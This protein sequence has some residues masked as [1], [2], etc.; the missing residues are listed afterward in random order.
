LKRSEVPTSSIAVLDE[1]IEI[2]NQSP[3]DVDLFDWSIA[4]AV[5]VRHR[6]YNGGV[7]ET[8]SASNA[9]IVFGG[10]LNG[11]TPSLPVLAFPA[12]EGSAGLALNNTG[13]ESIILRN[14]TNI[15]DRLLYA[16][17]S[18]SPVGSLTRFPTLN[19]PFVPSAYVGTNTSA[20]TQ[21]DGGVWTA[22]ATVP[23][24]VTPITLTYGSPVTLNYTAV[25][26]QAYTLWQANEVNDPFL[27]VNGGIATNTA[28]AFY[29]TNA[30]V[31]RQF[32]FIT[33]P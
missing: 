5:G 24:G 26:G 18:L 15:I 21:Y 17:T 8:L 4:D 16:E 27:V 1:Y 10:P 13:S 3:T 9:I 12:S 25:V 7:G 31:N 28:G 29:I 19:S 22:P 20:G 14:G 6:F 32:Y 33:K 11:N 30:P 2:V 23:T